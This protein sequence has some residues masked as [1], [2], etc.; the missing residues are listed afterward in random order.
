[1]SDGKINMDFHFD[2]KKRYLDAFLE[3][4]IDKWSPERPVIISAQTGAGKNHFI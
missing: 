3:D 1:M 4:E 2:D